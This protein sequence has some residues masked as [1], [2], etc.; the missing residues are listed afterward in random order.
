MGRRQGLGGELLDESADDIAK[1]LDRKKR[2][3]EW[4]IEQAR[5]AWAVHSRAAINTI[6]LT[7]AWQIQMRGLAAESD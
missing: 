4:H 1:A 3:I 5:N 2:T 6:L 7:T